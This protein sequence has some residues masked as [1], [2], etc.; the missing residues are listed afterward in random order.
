[1][2][3]SSKPS[4]FGNFR[5]PS[6]LGLVW[7]AIVDFHTHTPF[8]MRCTHRPPLAA[9]KLRSE[10]AAVETVETPSEVSSTTDVTRDS[11]GTT[12]EKGKDEGNDDSPHKSSTLRNLR[13]T[14]FSQAKLETRMLNV[15]C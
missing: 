7:D 8:T 3:L 15:E 14:R 6:G 11:L 4:I 5:L 2:K 12:Q 1:M 10:I 13:V 9:A